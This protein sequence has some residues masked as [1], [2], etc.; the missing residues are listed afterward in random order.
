MDTVPA[1]DSSD[2]EHAINCPH[3]LNTKSSPSYINQPEETRRSKLRSFVLKDK[4]VHLYEK[5]AYSKTKKWMDRTVVSASRKEKFIRMI[6]IFAIKNSADDEFWDKI[7][8]IFDKRTML[9]GNKQF[10]ERH[11]EH[12]LD[13]VEEDKAAGHEAYEIY[14]RWHKKYAKNYAQNSGQIM[15]LIKTSILKGIKPSNC[16]QALNVLGKKSA[17]ITSNSLQ[18]AL[19]EVDQLNR[20][21]E[22]AG[23]NSDMDFDKERFANI[24]DDFSY[25]SAD[26]IWGDE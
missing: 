8:Y 20:Q 3:L 9:G 19:M 24:G 13:K 6:A 4:A 1:I 14:D 22:K 17:P 15:T 11:L 23:A 5:I 26:K 25:D 16:A 2:I 12:Y 7:H 21:K 10:D 18:Y